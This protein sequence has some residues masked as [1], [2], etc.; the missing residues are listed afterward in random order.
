MLNFH[1]DSKRYRSSRHA[2]LVS[3]R[4]FSSTLLFFLS[5][6]LVCPTQTLGHRQ[7][8]SWST[9]AWN[10]QSS[11]LEITHR[12]HA[13]DA[14]AWLTARANAEIDI[15]D[16][17][18]QARF[19]LYCAERFKLQ[20]NQTWQNPE[21]LGAELKGNYLLTYQQLKLDAAPTSLF[22]EITILM[23]LFVDQEHVVNTAS[24]G[25]TK[26]LNFNLQN[27]SQGVKI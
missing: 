16:I 8:L 2:N 3:F 11:V 21:L 13:H 15:T 17:E 5:V 27:T 6:S 4:A 14:S 7:H 22:F 23:D 12:V 20:N 26:S 9:I 1:P 10:E 24:G 25:S 19:A 18:H